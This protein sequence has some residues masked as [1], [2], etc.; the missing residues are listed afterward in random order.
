MLRR[1]HRHSLQTLRLGRLGTH[2]AFGVGIVVI[3]FPWL[4][5]ARQRAV[6]RRWSRQLLDCLGVRLRVQDGTPRPGHGMV[7][8]NH[9]S[10]LDVFVI[11]AIAETTFVCKDDVRGWPVLGML[12]ARTGTVFIDR[13]SRS[14]ARRVNETLV[15]RLA[16]GERIAVFPEGTTGD[17]SGLLAFRPALLQAAIDAATHVQPLALRYADR[18]G[19]TASDFAYVGETTL[20]QSLCAVA[21]ARGV[22]ADLAVL[23]AIPAAT[24]PRRDLA[25][26][27]QDAIHAALSRHGPVVKME[28]DRGNAGLPGELAEANAH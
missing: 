18:H 14:A 26:R 23:D 22:T 20:W 6:K 21:G 10:W 25:G 12:C 16:D 28:S 17:G 4:S 7:V 2:L 1:L 11:N 9:I 19:A 24:L 13:G 15:A 3:A 5:P 27:A 8:A